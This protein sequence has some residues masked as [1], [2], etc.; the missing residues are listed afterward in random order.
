[1]SAPRPPR[2]EPSK[3]DSTQP[4]VRFDLVNVALATAVVIIVIQAFRFLGLIQS[5]LVLLALA[6]ILATTIE[7]LVTYLRRFGFRRGYGVL[8]IYL[9]LVLLLGV[10]LFLGAQ[11]IGQQLAALGSA[12]PDLSRRLGVLANSLP[13]GPIRDAAT[14][15]L[16]GAATG[17][18][19]Q[20]ISS[21]LSTGTLSGLVFA[22]LSVV[23]LIFAIVTVFVIAYFWISERLVI[24]RLMLRMVRPERR[25]QVLAIWETVEEKLGAW[26]RGQLLLMFVV[27][28][29]QGVGY[30][31]LGVHYALLL[32]IWAGLAEIIPMVGPYLGAAPAVLVALTQSPGLALLVVGYTVLVNVIESNVLVP[33]IMEQAVGLSPLTVILALLVGAALYGVVGA[34]LAV[35]I[36]AAIQAVLTELAAPST[37]PVTNVS[38]PPTGSA[39]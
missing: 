22:T 7:P 19:P 33:R 13:A 27:G 10:F 24:R 6:V 34:L 28:V 36:A 32:A 39:P 29:L 11:A 30:A 5:V 3:P 18:A 26:S 16:A 8:V 9:A 17:L 14:A 21:I 2:P 4:V 23:E 15:L 12:L 38:Q 1:M 35:P 37:S 20:G 25:E 31:I